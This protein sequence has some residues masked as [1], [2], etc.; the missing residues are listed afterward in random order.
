ML[1]N[2]ITDPIF[3]SYLEGQSLCYYSYSEKEDYPKIFHSLHNRVRFPKKAAK[4]VE[5]ESVQ[6][7]K[8]E[9]MFQKWCE[10]DFSDDDLESG[11]DCTSQSSD[12]MDE[13]FKD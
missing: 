7:E 6:S 11:T 8:S 2:Q 9:N 5:S 3:K 12:D 10:E 4:V 13:V 1:W